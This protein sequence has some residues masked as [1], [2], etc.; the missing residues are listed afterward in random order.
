MC[1]LVFQYRIE[2]LVVLLWIS[3]A[4]FTLSPLQLRSLLAR[5]NGQLC[6]ERE[7]GSSTVMAECML[8]GLACAGS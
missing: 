5:R 4:S 6:A 7:A 2:R 8:S 3:L 1:K